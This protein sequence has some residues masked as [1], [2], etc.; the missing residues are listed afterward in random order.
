LTPGLSSH[1]A[2]LWGIEHVSFCGTPLT[3]VQVAMPM[4]NIVIILVVLAITAYMTGDFPITIPAH[5]SD[6]DSVNFDEFQE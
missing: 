6:V 5:S 2:R 4:K 1:D 3:T